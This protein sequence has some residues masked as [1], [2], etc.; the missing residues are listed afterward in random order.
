MR[1]K[2]PSIFSVLEAKKSGGNALLRT[3]SLG[4][5]GTIQFSPLAN[6]GEIGPEQKVGGRENVDGTF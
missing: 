3:P 4:K 6:S 5:H 2:G 1:E